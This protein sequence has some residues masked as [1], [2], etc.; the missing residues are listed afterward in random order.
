MAEPGGE[1]GLRMAAFEHV[2]RLNEV[3]DHLTFVELFPGFTFLGELG[4][5]H[6]S[7]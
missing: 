1:V 5:V 3:H 4:D 2:R 6:S 7:S